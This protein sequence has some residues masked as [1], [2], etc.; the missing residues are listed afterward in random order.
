VFNRFLA[1]IKAI[2]GMEING[3]HE[4]VFTPTETDDTV[5]SEILSGT[6]RSMMQPA[7]TR[8]MSRARLSSSAP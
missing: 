1:I 7:A 3:R 8:R 4:I 6:S 2:A 5:V